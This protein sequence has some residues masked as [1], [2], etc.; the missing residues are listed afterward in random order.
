MKFFAL[1]SVGV[2]AIG[3]TMLLGSHPLFAGESNVVDFTYAI[4]S[5]GTNFNLSFAAVYDGNNKIT[6]TITYKLATDEAK[7][8]TQTFTFTK[9]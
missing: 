3:V 6:L 9:A 4:S 2:A 5:N 7:G 1:K 8:W